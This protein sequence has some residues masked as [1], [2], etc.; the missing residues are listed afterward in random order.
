M[1]G[2][3]LLL[4]ITVVLCIV[5]LCMRRRYRKKRYSVDDKV[6]YDLTDLK[7]NTG[8]DVNMDHNPSYVATTPNTVD[9]STIKP[10]S[11]V[12]SIT[13]NPSYYV[14]ITANPSYNVPTKPYS[15]TEDEYDYVQPNQY[16]QHSDLDESIKMDTNPSCGVGAITFSATLDIIADRSS[17]DATTE[18]YDYAYAHDDHLLHHKTA[19]ST[20]GDT[21]LTWSPYLT[22]ISN[23]TKVHNGASAK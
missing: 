15:K 19:A 17:H 22:L 10:R 7:L 13:S 5:I 1:G 4:M 14:P 16:N 3:I 8:A 2:V 20:T 9:Y 23:G 6:Y 11:S 18:E 12:V 21:K